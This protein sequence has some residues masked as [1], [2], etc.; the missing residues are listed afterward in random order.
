[1]SGIAQSGYNISM[2]ISITAQ[3][4][5]HLSPTMQ[6][7]LH[8]IR[9]LATE[10]T[11]AVYFVGGLVRDLLLGQSSHDLDVVLEGNALHF[12]EAI[13]SRYG[14]QL[15]LHPRFGTATWRPAESAAIIDF[16]TARAESYTQ[17]G[18][19]PVVEP[20]TI[21][22]DLARR[23]FTL[24][25]LAVRLDDP[26]FG[27]LLDLHGGLAD[28]QLGRLRVLHP[29]S[30]QDDATRI[31][32]GVRYEQRLG[33][34]FGA[35]TAVYLQRD[36]DYLRT[37]SGDRIRHELELILLEPNRAQMLA[38]LDELGALRF[39]AWRLCWVDEVRLWFERADTADLQDDE[40]LALYLALWL[41]PQKERTR[42]S[43][44]RY[45]RP[46]NDVQMLVNELAQAWA[47]IGQAVWSPTT[48]PSVLAQ[49][50]T[51]YRD[52][53]V[54]WR[55]LTAVAGLGTPLGQLLAQYEATWRHIQPTITG[56]TLKEMGLRPGPQF[57][58]LLTA[59]WAA[60]LDGLV[61]TE[62]EERALV[63]QLAM[64]DLKK[65]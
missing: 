20:A 2:T 28:L 47:D 60:K 24:N 15:T 37:I 58:T 35:N 64:S 38:R 39:V 36:L 13:Q 59:V 31:W 18:A 22:E 30:F 6:S 19:L 49:R 61:Q 5:R 53:R 46:T 17:P 14:G 4:L 55:A 40:R 12:A 51:P 26:H 7:H 54:L 9:Q 32:R 45:L 42:A 44:L 63:T 8:Q 16:I 48:P 41:L 3:L 62:A 29:R 52:S 65:R 21:V 11:T 25:A 27:T 50:L 33:F 57:R 1:M 43:A 10:Q 56:H 23:D 34:A